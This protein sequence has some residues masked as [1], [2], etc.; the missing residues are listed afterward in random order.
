MPRSRHQRRVMPW[1]LTV[2]CGLLNSSSAAFAEE[3]PA[4]PPNIVFIL[5]DDMGFSDAGCYGGEIRTPNLDALA[6][7]G[8]RFSQ[9]YNNGL[10]VPTRRCLLTGYYFNQTAKLRAGKGALQPAWIRVLPQY[11]TP[12]GYRCYHSGKWHLANLKGV[13]DAGFD[14]SYLLYDHNRYF[15]PERHSLDDVLLPPVGRDEGY[16]ATT[17]IVDYAVEFLREHHLSPD[18]GS[19]PFLLYL[20][21]ISP[22]F[23]LHAL[24]EDIDLY[25]DRYLQGWDAIREQ[26]W[27]RLK[28]IGLVNCDLSQRKTDVPPPVVI[29]TAGGIKDPLSV[30]GDAETPLAAP[31]NEL[32]DARKEFQAIKMS[33]HA[34]MITRMD[35]EIGRMLD[36]LRASGAMENTIIFF[37]S[38]NGA[39]AT[40]MVRGD[41]HDPHAEPGSAD[42]YLCLG[43]GWANTCCSPFRYHKVWAH[44]GGISSP[45]IVHWPAGIQGSGEIRRTPVHFIDFIPTFVELAGG[46]IDTH[47]P[48]PPLPGKSIVPCFARDTD[49]AR[50]YMFFENRGYGGFR[51]NRQGNLKLVASHDEPWALYDIATDRCEMND[52]ANQMPEKVLQ[53]ST[54]WERCRDTF[55]QQAGQD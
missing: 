45:L 30:L 21:F 39:C 35:K 11:L 38:D 48:R 34:A 44:E 10:C 36:Q 40:L 6:A 53:M 12:L 43:P 50:E 41:K 22:H 2:V 16:Y 20:A 27:R 46:R 24:Q 54:S 7:D 32:T 51:A 4:A 18:H 55:A 1:Y 49:L 3:K 5:A 19:K 23:P 14:H 52:L 25:R 42:S 47:E 29:E 9:C 17:A 26:R 8:L 33:I 15:S 37:A 31:W 28:N 13:A